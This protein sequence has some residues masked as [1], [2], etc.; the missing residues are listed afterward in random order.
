M[1]VTVETSALRCQ[2]ENQ[3]I[4]SHVINVMVEVT[5]RHL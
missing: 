2:C 1:R 4:F 5:G 3:A